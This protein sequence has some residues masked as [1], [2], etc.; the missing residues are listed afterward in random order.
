MA[1]AQWTGFVIHV[2][3]S[4]FCTKEMSMQYIH[5]K[6]WVMW[7]SYYIFGTKHSSEVSYKIP[8][9][10]KWGFYT[11]LFNWTLSVCKW[12]AISNSYEEKVLNQ[13]NK[14]SAQVQ[15]F[16]YI[17][18]FWY[19][20]GTH[21]FL[22]FLWFPLGDLDQPP[23]HY[24]ISVM[25]CRSWTYLN[26]L[27]IVYVSSSYNIFGEWSCSP[28][29]PKPPRYLLFALESLLLSGLWF[30][31]FPGVNW[32]AGT[33]LQWLCE[34]WNGKKAGFLWGDGWW[35]WEST[36]WQPRSWQCLITLSSSCNCF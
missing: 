24:L 6:I 33:Q 31:S 7:T 2:L 15:M 35:N 29:H 11:S 28:R 16:G 23:E 20:R 19:D 22:L 25:L 3:F 30:L 14:C 13:C 36:A 9:N 12:R 18:E 4:F 21:P 34:S 8:F 17:P 26:F 1:L 10:Y 32:S 27:L 5:F